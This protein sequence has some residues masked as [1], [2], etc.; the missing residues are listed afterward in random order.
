ME[1]KSR[2]TD[3][4]EFALEEPGLAVKK[5]LG[6]SAVRVVKKLEGDSGLERKA[7]GVRCGDNVPPSD[8]SRLVPRPMGADAAKELLR[9]ART[10]SAAPVCDIRKMPESASSGGTGEFGGARAGN[11]IGV[12]VAGRS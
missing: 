11:L 1:G 8:P 7:R 5:V 2:C 4:I 3:A 6:V 10:K 9:G 12:A